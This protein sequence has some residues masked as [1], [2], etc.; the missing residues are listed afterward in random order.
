MPRAHLTTASVIADAAVL[1]DSDGLA[2]VTVSAVAR[3]LGVKP[4]SLYEHVAGLGP[5]LD[6]VQV[7]ALGEVAERTAAAVAGRSGREAL[8]GLADAHRDYAIARPGA[9]AALQ[10]P[11]SPAVAGSPEAARVA[12]LL[13]A[14]VRGYRVPDD[15][16]VHAAR[17]VGATVNGFLALTR[18]EAFAHRP[19]SEDASWTAAV[20]A[21][22]RAL[23]SWP[24]G[25]DS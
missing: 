25:S 12:G 3:R 19:D 24:E 22:D 21:L 6:G 1:A 15:D 4:A 11:A 18:A 5:L 2:A 16:L 14:V 20:D 9:W 13:L 8:R 10:R 17:L 7:L 23:D